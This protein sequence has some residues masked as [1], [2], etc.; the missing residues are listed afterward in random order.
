M[1]ASGPRSAICALLLAAGIWCAPAFAQGANFG[2][3][4]SAFNG[5]QYP[6]AADMFTQYL[7]QQPGDALAHYYLGV[8]WHCLGRAQE[9]E[10]EYSW[11]K[12]NSADPE[13]LKRAEMGLAVVSR[14]RP[15]SQALASQPFAPVPVQVP[16]PGYQPE[17][18]QPAPSYGGGGYQQQQPQQQPQGG[19]G[20]T[21]GWLSPAG[22]QQAA[23][24][25]GA[26][27]SAQNAG[28]QGKIIDLYTDWCGWCKKFEPTF[29]QARAKYGNSIQ[30]E[31]LNAEQPPNDR[32]VK[33]YRV[34]GYP[35]LLFLD[36][37]G[38]LVKRIDGAPQ[39]LQDFEATIF[40]AYP[41]LASY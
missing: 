5:G 24:V 32:L 20:A 6:Q 4:V 36:N 38:K 9:A 11:V 21:T 35:T 40:Q 26:P 33:K 7:R 17:F 3:A 23:H 22:A 10:S 25:N 27:G 19:G 1:R 12:Q 30:F 18:G 39:S 41:S 31:R 13:L 29:M 2:V 16:Q 14:L 15:P 28:V 34:R 8:T 37:N